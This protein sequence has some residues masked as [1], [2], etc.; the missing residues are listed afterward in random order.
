MEMSKTMRKEKM[1]HK[2][3]SNTDLDF[4]DWRED[5][6]AEYPD[7]SEDEL[8]EKMYEINDLYIDDE[9]ANL[10]IQLSQP[11]IVI[12]DIGRWNGRVTGYKM[13]DS[14]NVKDCFEPLGEYIKWYVDEEGNFRADAYHHDGENHYLYRAFKKGTT[15]EQIEDLTDK[16]YNGEVTQADI[17]EV[18]ERLGGYIGKVYGWSEFCDCA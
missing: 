3:W 8:I 12:G 13:I 14:G 9:R 2:I 17:E 1:C 4:E 7:L 6:K 18:T 11:I 10:N 16:I 15:E 5:L